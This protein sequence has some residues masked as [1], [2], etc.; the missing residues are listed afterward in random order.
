MGLEDL[1][2]GLQARI[3]MTFIIMSD[4]YYVVYL[5]KSFYKFLT[6][7]DWRFFFP[8]VASFSAFMNN[9]NDILYFLLYEYIGVKGCETFLFFFRATASLNWTPISWLQTIRLVSFTKVFYKKSVY[10]TISAINIFLSGA[11]TISYYL[12]LLNFKEKDI[13]EE[14]NKFMFCS[15]EQAKKN[16]FNGIT[17]T[18]YVM[19]FDVCDST[20]SL[21][22]LVFTAYMALD[23]VTH[24]KF[25]HAKIKRMVDEG[26]IQLVVL[27]VSKITCYTLMYY[28]QK[29]E[30]MIED[31]VWDILSVIVIICSFRLVNVRYSRIGSK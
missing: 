7:K 26:L 16:L 2:P 17:Y 25:H 29:K 31:I 23:S 24:L 11:Y 14:T 28:L 4:Y 10:Y 5:V 21:G 3:N 9:I 19:I 13:G 12:N 22:V 18:Q 1:D 20:F 30:L 6:T 27:T 15:V 8:I